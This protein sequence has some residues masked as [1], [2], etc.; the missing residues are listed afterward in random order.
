MSRLVWDSSS[1]VLYGLHGQGSMALA[2]S[3]VDCGSDKQ[4]LCFDSSSMYSPRS[5]SY[6]YNLVNLDSGI[7]TE[8]CL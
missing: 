2:R 7:P 5:Y 6:A 8:R 1:F 4:P 3:Y